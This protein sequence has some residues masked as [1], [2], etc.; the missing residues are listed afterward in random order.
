MAKF[1]VST[2]FEPRVFWEL[3]YSE[4]QAIVEELNRRK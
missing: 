1:C 2:G 4:Y 3:S